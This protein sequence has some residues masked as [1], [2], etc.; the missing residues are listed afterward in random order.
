MLPIIDR[1]ERK[2][3][4]TYLEVDGLMETHV[5]LSPKTPPGDPPEPEELIKVLYIIFKN[6]RLYI[7]YVHVS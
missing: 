2:K 1:R 5:T 6:L 4:E 7:Y 3:S